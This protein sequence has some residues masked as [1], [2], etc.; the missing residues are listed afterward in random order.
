MTLLVHGSEGLKKAQNA[1]EALYKG[2]VEVLGQ[3]N[4]SDLGQ[5][6]AGAT[7]LDIL[8]EA[9]QTV[10]DLSMKVGCFPTQRKY[11]LKYFE[12]YSI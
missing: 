10:L 6:F 8:P 2:N 11:A 5:L 1:T 4:V 12:I 9:G 7:V 3:M